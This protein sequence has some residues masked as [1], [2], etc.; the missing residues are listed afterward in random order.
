MLA[1]KKALHLL[2]GGPILSTVFRCQTLCGGCSAKGRGYENE[3][4]TFIVLKEFITAREICKG[5]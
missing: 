1:G 5:M 3:Q 4:D 2:T